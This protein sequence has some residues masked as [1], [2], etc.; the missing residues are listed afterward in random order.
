[1]TR[2]VLKYGVL[3]RP[4]DIAGLYPLPIIKTQ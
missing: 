3:G 1:M 4:I 2:L